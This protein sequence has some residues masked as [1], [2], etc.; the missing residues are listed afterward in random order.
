MKEF[1]YNEETRIHTLDGKVIPSVSNIVAP[2][3]MDYSK[4]HPGKLAHKKDLGIAFHECIRLFLANDLDEESIDEELI[5]PMRQFKEFWLEDENVGRNPIITSIEKSFCNEKLKY[6]GKPDF[7]TEDTIY[8]W[9]LRKYDPICDPLRMAGY[10]GLINDFPPKRKV[11]VE[12]SLDSGYRVHNAEKKQAWSFFR[13]LLE[14]FQ[15]NKEWDL[16]IEQWKKSC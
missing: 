9:K 16:K 6:C 4:A 3:S 12:F 8:D 14:R 2:L 5:I 1:V 11:V 10:A 13:L 7:V 15:K